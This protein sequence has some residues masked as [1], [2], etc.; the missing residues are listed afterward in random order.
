MFSDKILIF[1][2]R[3]RHIYFC[4]RKDSV[5][6]LLSVLLLIFLLNFA[7][8]LN[9]STIKSINKHNNINQFKVKPSIYAHRLPLDIFFLGNF[10]LF[11]KQGLRQVLQVYDA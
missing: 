4:I 7:E 5:L 9:L 10:A 6:F 11:S 3:F 2:T 1:L 8:A